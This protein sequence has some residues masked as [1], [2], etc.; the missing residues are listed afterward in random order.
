MKTK[1]ILLLLITFVAGFFIGS[2][3]TGRVTKSKV[4]KIKSINTPEGFR[5][6]IFRIIEATETQKPSLIPVLDS[7]SD[8][9]WQLM[10]KSWEEQKLMFNQ[11]D[12]AIKPLISVQQFDLLMEHKQKVLKNKDVKNAR[13]NKNTVK[14]TK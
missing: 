14:D 3:T 2:I 7:F 1:Y 12:A 9:H 8:I 5:E 4:Q 10:K 11:M 6:H 13:R